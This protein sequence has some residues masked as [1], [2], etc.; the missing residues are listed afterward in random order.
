MPCGGD[1]PGGKGVPDRTDV[2]GKKAVPS[3]A[4]KL[5]RKAV[6]G[7]TD[8]PD[9]KAVPGSADKLEK[10]AVPGMTDKLE[11]KA[12]P[13]RTDVPGKKAVRDRKD[14]PVRKHMPDRKRLALWT[15][16][17][18]VL[19]I[20]ASWHFLD[21]RAG[22]LETGDRW[23]YG[24]Y[25]AVCVWAGLTASGLGYVIFVRDKWKM[26]QIF[27]A[28]SLSLGILFLFILPPL[29]APD[30][31]SHYISAYQLSKMCIRD[32]SYLKPLTAVSYMTRMLLSILL[33]QNFR[34][35]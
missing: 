3:R 20:L 16:C 12:V 29:S 23:L 31:V 15:G 26:E 4:D 18:I 32:R 33:I 10:K 7:M 25:A 21:V 1:E 35:R 19:L 24:W 13:G 5:E 6:P 30:E 8:K 14:I 27:A 9:K 22:V 17:G 28:A 34:K 11:K 2:L